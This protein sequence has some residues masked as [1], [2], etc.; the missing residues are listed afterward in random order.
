MKFVYPIAAIVA[1]AVQDPPAVDAYMYSN[2]PMRGKF[3]VKNAVGRCD[4][5]S[6]FASSPRGERYRQRQER[7]NE[8]FR[9]LQKEMNDSYGGGRRRKGNGSGRRSGDMFMMDMPPGFYQEVDKEAVKKWVDKAFNL[10][11]EWNEDFSPTDQDREANKELLDKSRD[12]VDRLYNAQEE[13]SAAGTTEA[14]TEVNTG[15][16]AIDKTTTNAEASNQDP[17]DPKLLK[18]ETPYSENRS[19]DVM[20][21]IAV[22]LPGVERSD[23]DI[24]L[25]GD[26]M[27][28]EAERRPN[29]DGQSGRKYMKKFVFI[30][31]EVDVDQIDATLKNGILVVSAPKKQKE[32]EQP[33]KIE[34]N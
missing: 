33:R 10:A 19:N 12:W 15:D 16:E 11:S 1:M 5:T 30:V 20:F 21:Q 34:I 17:Q 22:D 24:S 29:E 28:I 8:A 32:E 14:D 31:E 2:G 25:Q 3:S 4:P 13:V 6:S 26:F 7:V 18:P 27:A 23:I 9:E